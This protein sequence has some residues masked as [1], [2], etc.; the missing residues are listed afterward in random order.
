ML[1]NLQ[2][3]LKTTSKKVTKKTTKATDELISGT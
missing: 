1:N 2:D 3:G